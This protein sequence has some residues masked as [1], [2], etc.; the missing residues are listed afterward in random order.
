MSGV[1]VLALLALA[2]AAT[3]RVVL[4]VIER[5]ADRRRRQDGNFLGT[6]PSLWVKE[7]E[8]VDL[9][10][11][12]WGLSPK[13]RDQLLKRWLGDV[14]GARR[15]DVV[16]KSLRRERDQQQRAGSARGPADA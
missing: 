14:L 16:L 13:A 3:V 1:A 7:A 12:A 4:D 6:K 11:A 10:A 15:A 9:A 8:V 5:A 2:A